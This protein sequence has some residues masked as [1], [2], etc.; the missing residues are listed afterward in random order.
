MV[1][2]N[3]RL[4]KRMGAHYLSHDKYVD[5]GSYSDVK[6]FPVE[7]VRLELSCKLVFFSLKKIRF[8]ELG[9]ETEKRPNVNFCQLKVV[10]FH[11]GIASHICYYCS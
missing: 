8:K 10:A 1:I 7:I 3:N 4:I 2:D 9:C 6:G 11:H 5:G